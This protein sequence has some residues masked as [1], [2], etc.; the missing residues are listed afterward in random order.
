MKASF[1][2]SNIFTKLGI[3][4]MKKN[5]LLWIFRIFYNFTKEN[6]FL[7]K[8]S[9]QKGIISDASVEMNGFL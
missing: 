4:V 8:I 9:V 7:M 6:H 1:L 2:P 5:H 3:K